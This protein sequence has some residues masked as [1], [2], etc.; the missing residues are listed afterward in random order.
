MIWD[1]Q[2]GMIQ[3]LSMD[4]QD[5][6]ATELVPPGCS[7]TS[8]PFEWRCAFWTAYCDS[9]PGV[10]N[11]ILKLCK[12]LLERQGV[13]FFGLL[14]NRSLRSPINLRMF[15]L[16]RFKS[17]WMSRWLHSAVKLPTQRNGLNTIVAPSITFALGRNDPTCQV[18]SIPSCA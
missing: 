18:L 8:H 15:I 9:F 16:N 6:Q 2:A 10:W 12:K 7:A 13:L 5:E 14:R 11:H 3:F 4:L 1:C 17:T